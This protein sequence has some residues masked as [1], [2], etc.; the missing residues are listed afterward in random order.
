[1]VEDAMNNYKIIIQKLEIDDRQVRV[2]TKNPRIE[3]NQLI[4]NA[5]HKN[6]IVEID[7]DNCAPLIQDLTYIEMNGKGEIIKDRS[8]PDKY[9][10]F[11]DCWRYIINIAVKP[12][13]GLG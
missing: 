6:W 11:L 12:H 10:D 4:V 9:C 5:A 1:M 13:L 8:S 3:E 2:P 7:P